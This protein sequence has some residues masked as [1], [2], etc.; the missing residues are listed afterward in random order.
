M[1]LL[2]LFKLKKSLKSKL[3][4][5]KLLKLNQKFQFNQLLKLLSRRT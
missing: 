5:Q 3:N 2:R 4:S 1:K